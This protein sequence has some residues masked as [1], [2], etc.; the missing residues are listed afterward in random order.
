MTV[1][2]WNPGANANSGIDIQFLDHCLA[3][4][5]S[6][7]INNI[8]SALSPE[9]SQMQGI[10]QLSDEQWQQAVNHYNDEQLIALIRFFTLIETQ[11][12][13]WDA[14][15]QS[16]VIKINHVL[17]NRGVKLDKTVLQWIR[18]NS[19]NRFLPNGAIF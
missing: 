11:L 6:E 17:K 15:A 9:Q 7:S 16:P 8:A 13:H 3:I 1:G 2:S 5:Q 4:A 14:G 19:S 12:T 18:K 10:V